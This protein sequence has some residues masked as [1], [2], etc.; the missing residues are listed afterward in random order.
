M[1]Q[2]TV[3]DLFAAIRATIA[4]I[5]GEP[6]S[7]TAWLDLERTAGSRYRRRSRTRGRPTQ[8]QPP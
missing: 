6:M 4:A 8:L 2:P 3:K 7:G 1:S 5:P